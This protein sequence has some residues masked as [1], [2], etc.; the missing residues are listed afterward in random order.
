MQIVDLE[1]L[2]SLRVY[3][4]TRPLW[5]RKA[6]VALD[7]A[8]GAPSP[9]H[10]DFCYKRHRDFCNDVLSFQIGRLGSHANITFGN[11][12]ILRLRIFP[13]GRKLIS[14]FKTVLDHLHIEDLGIFS[15]KV[16]SF[17]ESA[18]SV[19][20]PALKD[21]VILRIIFDREAP[22]SGFRVN[23][24]NQDL[25]C[26]Y[27]MNHPTHGIQTPGARPFPFSRN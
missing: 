2:R 3:S 18:V 8:P 23:I 7:A 21:L 13:G 20:S 26:T 27:S 19:W 10:R 22:V 5:R 6:G 15:G 17:M 16:P 25:M 4:Q 11:I 12:S 14:L 24:E 9:N 1:S